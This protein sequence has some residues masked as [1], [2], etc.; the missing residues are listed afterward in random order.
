MSS[1][2]QY[3]DFSRVPHFVGNLWSV[4]ASTSSTLLIAALTYFWD[5]MVHPSKPLTVMVSSCAPKYTS[6]WTI[7]SSL[8]LKMA[9]MPWSTFV[10]SSLMATRSIPHHQ[11][12]KL[13]ISKHLDL[14]LLDGS[15]CHARF[16]QGVSERQ[17][18]SF[19]THT[20]PSSQT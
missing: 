1:S 4:L 20:M 17:H 13:A 18:Q 14:L 19:S 8:N 3:P 5:D 15:Q 10:A 7:L 9:W 12:F 16:P 6:G 11:P 2:G